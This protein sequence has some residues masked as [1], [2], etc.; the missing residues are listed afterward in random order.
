MSVH[1]QTLD[2]W[3]HLIWLDTDH[4]GCA[5]TV[6]RLAAE[7]RA[8][9]LLILADDDLLLPGCLEKH[10]ECDGD[11]V[12]SKPLV[13]GEDAAQFHAAP[14]NIP[15]CSLIR[16]EL[17]DRV[18]GYDEQLEETEDARFYEKALELGA[19]FTECVYPCWVYRFHNGNKS[20]GHRPWRA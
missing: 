19:V 9:R 14:P 17:W 12:Y 3:E 6:N 15:S 11:I 13:W 2:Q 18:G 5:V 4:A 1:A 16:K 8:D 20:R 7:A 10:L